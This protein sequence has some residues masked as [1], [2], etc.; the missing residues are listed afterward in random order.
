MKLYKAAFIL[1]LIFASSQAQSIEQ[2]VVMDGGNSCSSGFKRPSTNGCRFFADNSPGYTWAGTQGSNHLAPTSCYTVSNKV[3]MN[4]HGRGRSQANNYPICESLTTPPTMSTSPSSVPSTLPSSVPTTAA[5]IPS[6]S[7]TPT[8]TKAELTEWFIFNNGNITETPISGGD[9]VQITLPF[10]SSNRD[11][12]V[13]VWINDCVTPFDTNSNYFTVETTSPN[14]N[15]PDG[16]IQFDT[17]LSMNVT[18]LNGTSY[19]NAFIDGTRGGWVEACVETYLQFTD[20]L[21]LGNDNP[22]QKVVFKNNLLN[23]SVSLNSDFEVDGMNVER[24]DAKREDIYTDYSEYIKVYECEEGA[25]DIN[26]SG[27]I[28]NQG[29]QI[30]ICVTDT[31]NS[32]VQVEEFVNFRISQ[33]GKDDYFFIRN[34]L[35]NSDITTPVCVDDANAGRRVCYCKIRALARF[36]DASEPTDLI[37]SGSV[38]MI[39]DGRTVR[40]NLHMPLPNLEKNKEDILGA[41]TRRVQNGK[42][43]G[44]DF[45][46]V[47]PIGSINNNAAPVCITA[48]MLGLGFIAAGAF[49]V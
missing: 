18:A 33:D 32:I 6:P 36:F 43:G 45:Q 17:L 2:Y 9:I 46:V 3:Y 7:F 34:S 1:S 40:R 23:M 44:G 29:D 37:I 13:N 11:H 8:M 27:K 12:G 30:T 10:N 26:A 42:E 22:T 4:Y 28:Y 24:E 48:T 31:S 15:F 38:F 39:R 47:I 5:P 20:T 49:I 21:N 35:W 25:L 19:W 41:S 16:F 14:S